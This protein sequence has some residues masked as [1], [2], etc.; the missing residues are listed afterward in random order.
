MGS[1]DRAHGAV[2]VGVR[3]S[4]ACVCVGVMLSKGKGE[5][6]KSRA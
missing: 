3:E 6:A 1:L 4:Y 5:V 2:G